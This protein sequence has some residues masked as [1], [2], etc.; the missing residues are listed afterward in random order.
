MS[1]ELIEV[2]TEG[3]TERMAR[4][5]E[6]TR[7]EFTGVRTGRATPALIDKLPVEYYGSE[8]PMQQLASFSVPEAR[9]LLVAPFD[10]GAMGAI[11]RAIQLADLGLNPS[12]DGT[13]IRLA[14]PPLTSERRAELVKVVRGFAE[15]GRISVRNVRRSARRELEELGDEA[16]VSDDDLTRAN[17]DL[18][19]ITQSYESEISQALAQKERELLED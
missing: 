1:S 3:A 7:N 8:V 17:K 5:V 4:A 9:Q 11:E 2:V 14:F 15:E 19:K 12:N 16:D 13:I 6:H 18:D 10:K